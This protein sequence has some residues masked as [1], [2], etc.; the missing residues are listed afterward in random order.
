MEKFENLMQLSYENRK[1]WIHIDKQDEN[2]GDAILNCYLGNVLTDN[3]KEELVSVFTPTYK[4]GEKIRR[5]YESLKNQSY[6][7][8]EWVIVDDSDDK[9]TWDMLKKLADEEPRISLYKSAYNSGV[10]GEVKHQACMLSKGNILAELDHDD[11]FTNTAIEYL[12]DAFKKFPEAGFAYTDCAEVHETGENAYYNDGWAFGYGS[13]RREQYY[14]REL[15]VSNYP[16]INA[17]TM[18]HIVGAPNH[19]RAWRK[20]TYFNIGGH[21]RD[22]HV[23]DDYEL[24]IRTF[25]NTRIIKIPVLGYIQ[26]YNVSGNTQRKR[27]KEIQRLVRYFREFYD[28]KIHER[29]LELGVEDFVWNDKY[30]VS[31][32]NMESKF[33][34]DCHIIYS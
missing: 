8:W 12:V 13:Y 21:D 34:Q 17:K 16:G 22:I 1:K 33:D 3:N 10:I 25:L 5:P 23:C 9:E 31:D 28:V 2:T 4:T 7:N 20:D 30:N 11:Q 32:L 15:L 19:V 18:R 6:K 27:N 26:Y 24:I 14:G 29:L